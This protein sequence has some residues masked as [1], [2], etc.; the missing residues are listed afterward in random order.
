MSKVIS[1]IFCLTVVLTVNAQFAASLLNNEFLRLDKD[2]VIIE[3]DTKLR[4]TY[5]WEM[6]FDSI[7]WI[8]ADSMVTQ[9]KIQFYADTMVM[10]RYRIKELNCLEPTFSDTIYIFNNTNSVRNYFDMG[11]TLYQLV[12]IGITVQE[13]IQSGIFVGN[14]LDD[15]FDSTFLLANDLIGELWDID[16]NKYGWV[17]IGNQKWMTENLKTTRYNDSTV[18]PLITDNA[19]W[20]N[21]T[22]GAYCHYNNLDSISNTYGFLY[23]WFVADITSNGLKNVCPAGWHVPTLAEWDTLIKKVGGNTGGGKLKEEGITHW[24]HPNL[25][26]TNESLFTALPGG[27]RNTDGD[28]Y[29]KNDGA[30]FWTT[31]KPT[32]EA[33]YMIYLLSNSQMVIPWNFSW[34]TNYGHSIRC[35]ED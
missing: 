3:T 4:G 11:I 12:G 23:N 14:F 2:S 34:H 1:T 21:T 28:Y 26:A 10:F 5:Q 31:H 22:D 33:P 8:P 25:N 29:A 20:Q 16:S 35:V 19:L 24:G 30:Y 18:I 9:G 7:N 6:S 27:Y 15:G 13:L 32:F 17:Q